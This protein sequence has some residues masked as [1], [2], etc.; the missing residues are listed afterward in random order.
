MAMHTVALGEW[1]GSIVAAYGFDSW[2]WIWAHGNNAGLRADREDPNLLVPGDKL[3]VPDTKVK[4]ENRPTDQ[5]HVFE[6]QLSKNKLILR[7]NG[8]AVYIQNFGPIAYTVTV[9][10]DSTTGN[11]ASENDTV[12][13]PLPIGAKEAILEMGGIT[14]NL[15]IGGLQPIT[16]LGGMQARLNNQGYFDGP[17]DGQ[18]GP[19]TK[20][21]VIGFQEYYSLKVDGVIGSQ[22]RGQMKTVYGS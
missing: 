20:Q 9:D 13:I 4:T 15:K 17:V 22:T 2:D 3:Y 14:K 12:E 8:V 6:R 18:N 10:G 1:I 7:F 5:P 11:I 19:L 16:H 21:G